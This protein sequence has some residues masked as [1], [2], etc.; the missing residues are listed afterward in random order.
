MA[1]NNIFSSEVLLGKEVEKCSRS[2]N[3]FVTDDPLKNTDLFERSDYG[4][5]VP[6]W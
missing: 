3:N 2:E 5:A 4:L 6:D 1:F